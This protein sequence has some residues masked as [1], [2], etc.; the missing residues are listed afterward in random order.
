MIIGAH[1]DNVVNARAMVDYAISLRAYP[2]F[3]GSKII[4][5]PERN[6]F[7]LSSILSLTLGASRG[8]FCNFLMYAD[9]DKRG[10]LTDDKTK[11]QGVGALQRALEKREIKLYAP[12]RA[13]LIEEWRR[14]LVELDNHVQSWDPEDGAASRGG[15]RGR[16]RVRYHAAT[17]KDDRAMTLI[18]GRLVIGTFGAAAEE[19]CVQQTN[20]AQTLCNCGRGVGH[21]G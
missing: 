21:A 2:A 12:F 3:R 1:N 7:G 8:R 14:T 6:A 10:F 17:G 19:V 20:G 13:K 5:V 9:K 4:F 15:H 18:I 16:K 11:A